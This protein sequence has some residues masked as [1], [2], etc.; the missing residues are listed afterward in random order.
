MTVEELKINLSLQA[1][2]GHFFGNKTKEE[3][4]L[5]AKKWVNRTIKEPSKELDRL[6]RPYF[7]LGDEEPKD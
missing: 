7:W 3:A 6:C 5:L 1:R 2:D 4:V